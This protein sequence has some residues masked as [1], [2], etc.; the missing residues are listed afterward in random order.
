MQPEAALTLTLEM[1]SL[2]LSFLSLL[3][4]ISQPKK[5]VEWYDSSKLKPGSRCKVNFNNDGYI[6]LS[7]VRNNYILAYYN[8]AY[9]YMLDFVRNSIKV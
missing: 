2:C 5:L 4:V 8:S 9:L 1:I 6:S 3:G 7:I